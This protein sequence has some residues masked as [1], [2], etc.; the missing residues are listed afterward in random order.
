[1]GAADQNPPAHDPEATDPD[2]TVGGGEGMELYQGQLQRQLVSETELVRLIT[3]QMRLHEGCERVSV[4]QVT[5]LPAPDEGGCNWSS[6]I[7]LD[8]AGVSPT[9]YGL[10]YADI[11]GQARAMWNLD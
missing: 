8:A 10:A 9:V 3:D 1:M 11:I 6:S 5:R 7:V 4:I 2:A